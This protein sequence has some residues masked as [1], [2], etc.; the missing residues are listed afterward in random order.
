MFNSEIVYVRKCLYIIWYT[1]KVSLI[2]ILLV[3]P[4]VENMSKM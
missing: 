2:F 3:L 4:K 1:Q